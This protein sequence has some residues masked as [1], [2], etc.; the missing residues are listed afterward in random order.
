[1][2]LLEDRHDLALQIRWVHSVQHC[3]QLKLVEEVGAL[4]L[5]H[6]L[7]IVQSILE[8]FDIVVNDQRADLVDFEVAVVPKQ[9][10]LKLLD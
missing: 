10:A 2:R 3:V 7:H 9:L 4:S 6:S 1:M 8:E 5:S